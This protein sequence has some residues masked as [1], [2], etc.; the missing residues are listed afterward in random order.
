MSG[1]KGR[2]IAKARLID[3]LSEP[4]P[5]LVEGLIP[6]K[7]G[8]C[9][10]EDVPA[11]VAGAGSPARGRG[12]RAGAEPV[13]APS[14]VAHRPAGLGGPRHLAWLSE[15]GRHRRRPGT[16]TTDAGR[17]TEIEREKRAE[18]GQRDPAGGG[19]HVAC[20]VLVLSSRRRSP[21]KIFWRRGRPVLTRGA[22]SINPRSLRFAG[23]ARRRPRPEPALGRPIRTSRSIAS[24]AWSRRSR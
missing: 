15:A 18:T 12:P 22:S 1:G 24:A 14:C 11:G 8:S 6:R 23:I 2:L 20:Q 16:T 7:V 4:S 21:S 5:G 13:V 19:L 10:P 3:S 17:L 9:R